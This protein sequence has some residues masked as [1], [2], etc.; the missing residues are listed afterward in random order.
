VKCFFEEVRL[1]NGRFSGC[2]FSECNFSLADVSESAFLKTRFENL[3][4]LGI[5]WTVADG[6]SAALPSR[7]DFSTDLNHRIFNRLEYKG[8]Q[9]KNCKAHEVDFRNA[10]LSRGSFSGTDLAQSFLTKPT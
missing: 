3:E 2:A 1:R 4:F 7:K 8:I 6:S 9:I 5:N 10:K